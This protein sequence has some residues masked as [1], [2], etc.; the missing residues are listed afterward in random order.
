[1][2]ESQITELIREKIPDASIEVQ[3]NG[4]SFMLKIVSA[5]FEGARSLKRQQM[6][7]ACINEKIKNGEMHAVTMRLFTPSEWEK[8]QKFSF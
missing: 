7:Y 5:A 4:N 3:I 1:M 8:Q 2:L 6:V